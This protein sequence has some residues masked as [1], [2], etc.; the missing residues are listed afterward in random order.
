MKKYHSK[1]IALVIAALT[2]IVVLGSFIALAET[3]SETELPPPPDEIATKASYSPTAHLVGRDGRPVP[4]KPLSN[5]YRAWKESIKNGA[6]I[7][8]PEDLEPAW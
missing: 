3:G 4:P 2:G 8:R 7:P 1:D 6:L 5:D